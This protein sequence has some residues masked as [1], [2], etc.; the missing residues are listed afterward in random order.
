[1]SALLN[2]RPTVDIGIS[3]PH[4]CKLLTAANP[5]VYRFQRADFTTASSGY[6]AGTY[7][8]TV[9]GNVT[10]SFP[11]LKRFRA[12]KWSIGYNTGLLTVATSGFSAGVTT[13]TAN[14]VFPLLNPGGAVPSGI[15]YLNIAPLSEQIAGNTGISLYYLSADVYDAA[16]GLLMATVQGAPDATG[17]IAIDVAPA[18][19]S[20]LSPENLYDYTTPLGSQLDAGI[21]KR[22]YIK[23]TELWTGSANGATDDSA[24]VLVA[25]LGARQIGNIYGATLAEYCCF[26]G[27]YGT[28]PVHGK[29]LTLLT[30]PKLWTGQPFTLSYAIDPAATAVNVS[31]TYRDII[32]TNIGSASYAIVAAV[33]QCI[34]R[35]DPQQAWFIAN[36]TVMPTTIATIQIQIDSGGSSNNAIIQVDVI[37]STYLQNLVTLYW[38]NSLGGDSYWTFNYLQDQ[39]YKYNGTN[40]NRRINLF[41]RGLSQTEWD[42]IQECT[43]LGEVFQSPLIEMYPTGGAFPTQNK[44][45]QRVGQQ[46]YLVSSTSAK[47]GVIVVPTEQTT[48]TDKYDNSIKILVELPESQYA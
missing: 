21:F 19:R 17:G 30:R 35:V 9:A 12:Q 15:V 39:S 1:M 33:N 14:I 46:C 16:T 45:Q 26:Q 8:F 24:T 6:G 41:A 31:M 3:S 10:A 7:T 23:Y 29:P 20:Y 25:V 5:N 38:R 44:I 18:L 27:A 34:I 47:V 48:Q 28:G 37:D 40:K 32:G 43:T 11:F 13:I 2:N 36:G 4:T 42:A 22:F